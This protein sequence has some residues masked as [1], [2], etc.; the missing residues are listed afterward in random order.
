MINV[1]EELAKQIGS[2]TISAIELTAQVHVIQEQNKMLQ[3]Q[4]ETLNKANEKKSVV[5]KKGDPK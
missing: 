2:L 5:P 1:R 4:I 3:E